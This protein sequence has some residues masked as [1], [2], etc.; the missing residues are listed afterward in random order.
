[1]CIWQISIGAT[2]VLLKAQES[3]LAGT[4]Q[5]TAHAGCQRLRVLKQAPGSARCARWFSVA[6]LLRFQCH[7][8]DTKDGRLPNFWSLCK[9][10]VVCSC[11]FRGR[12]ATEEAPLGSLLR[13]TGTKNMFENSLLPGPCWESQ[14]FP[15]ALGV[16]FFSATSAFSELRHENAT[17]FSYPGTDAFF[18][19]QLPHAESYASNRGPPVTPFFEAQRRLL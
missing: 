1:M 17:M 6:L 15:A 4:R 14:G 7:Q 13:L 8:K 10:A 3:H 2:S 11:I 16:W 18:H 5:P 19:F 9:S 12:V